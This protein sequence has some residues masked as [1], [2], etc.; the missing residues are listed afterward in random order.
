MATMTSS[1]SSSSSP[2]F[3]LIGKTLYN[4]HHIMQIEPIEGDY[5]LEAMFT[6]QC[7]SK[8]MQ[9]LPKY[10]LEREKDQIW[11]SFEDAATRDKSLA[12]LISGDTLVVDLGTSWYMVHHKIQ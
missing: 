3:V 11:A 7:A 5:A 4:I 10:P 8:S 12:R 6:V 9:V 2:V 1:S